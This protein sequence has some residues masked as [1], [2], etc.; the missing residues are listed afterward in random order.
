MSLPPANVGLWE[1]LVPCN[2]NDG[3]PI[4]T[5]HHRGWD[6][7]VRKVIGGLTILPPAKGQWIEPVSERLYSERMIPV[8]LMATRGQMEEIADI[9]L[10]HYAQK[11]VMY[12]KVSDEAVI[13]HAKT[14]PKERP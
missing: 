11:A 1:I 4:R 14:E 13:K 9:T 2:W 12:F 5:K 6:T 7:R 3:V 8:R 10:Q